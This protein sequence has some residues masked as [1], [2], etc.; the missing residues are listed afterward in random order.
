MK[1]KVL[2]F[3]LIAFCFSTYAQNIGEIAL[4][5]PKDSGGRICKKAITALGQITPG[6]KIFDIPQGMIF[7]GKY[8]GNG[9]WLTFDS[10]EN[11]FQGVEKLIPE[12]FNPMLVTGK[13][14]IREEYATEF[15]TRKDK[16]TAIYTMSISQKTENLP[17]SCGNVIVT[18]KYQKGINGNASVYKYYGK[19]HPYYIELTYLASND[20]SL[21][22]LKFTPIYVDALNSPYR[23]SIIG[24]Y[25]KDKHFTPLR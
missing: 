9:Y 7:E 2:F 18:M 20:G 25:L 11:V 1:L 4:L 3:T 22:R 10:I 19:L 8:G 16:P 5:R 15:P 24:I 12:K 14:F 13:N 23:D 21:K 6:E 17:D